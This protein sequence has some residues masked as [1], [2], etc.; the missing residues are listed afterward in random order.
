MIATVM[1][2]WGSGR[3]SVS[4]AVPKPQ[5]T[6]SPTHSASNGFSDEMLPVTRNVNSA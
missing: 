3:N 6:L 4:G 2:H 1:Q 5:V